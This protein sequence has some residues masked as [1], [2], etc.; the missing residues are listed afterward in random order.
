M[1]N[2]VGKLNEYPSHFVLAYDSTH[3][4]LACDILKKYDIPCVKMPDLTVANL[5]INLP[6]DLNPVLVTRS[7]V[8]ISV[9][10]GRQRN[11]HK[12][13]V[14]NRCR[15]V[16][17]G[18]RGSEVI[19]NECCCHLVEMRLT[20]RIGIDSRVSHRT[21]L[22]WCCHDLPL[23]FAGI[24]IGLAGLEHELLRS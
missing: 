16:H 20:V 8:P 5:D 19:R 21:P 4:P 7:G 15:H 1:A 10:T 24:F 22:Q 13:G 14:W 17:R 11:E 23:V 3:M 9:P 18:R 12:L 2:S 6:G